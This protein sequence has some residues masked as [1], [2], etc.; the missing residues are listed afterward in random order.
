MQQQQQLASS[1]VGVDD[2]RPRLESIAGTTAHST[3]RCSNCRP[4]IILY[5]HRHG[6]SGSYLC[7]E[8]SI[9]IL[10]PASTLADETNEIGAITV[11]IPAL[12]TG[13]A[14]A[15]IGLVTLHIIT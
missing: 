7:Y 15:R 5:T 13:D 14:A 9:I 4:A 8:I 11:C 12:Q 3:I 6:K 10:T 2:K 1:S